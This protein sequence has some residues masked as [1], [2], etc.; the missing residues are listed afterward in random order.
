MGANPAVLKTSRSNLPP[1]GHPVLEAEESVAFELVRSLDE[2]QRSRAVIASEP[3]PEIRGAGAPQPPREPSVGIGF[4]DLSAAQQALLRRLVDVYCDAMPEEVVAE[5]RRLIEAADGGWAAVRFAWA[6][7][8]EPGVGHY[9][10]VEG[11][12]LV[13]ELCNVQPDAEG[14]PANHIHCVWRDRTGDFDLPAK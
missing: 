1:V 10:R 9:Y 8:L 13:I 4:D 7:R 5:R 3:P 11:P 6:G 14:N 12:T 2:G